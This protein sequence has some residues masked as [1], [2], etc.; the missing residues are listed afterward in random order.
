MSI[1]IVTGASKGIGLGITEG[2][3]QLGAKVVGL[4]RSETLLKEI[5]SKHGKDKF[6]FV[7][8]DITDSNVLDNLVNLAASL[9]QING[10][11]HNAG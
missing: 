9:G 7:V 10:I 3:I 1:Y 8:G 11:V 6:E 4:A 2:I 5:Q